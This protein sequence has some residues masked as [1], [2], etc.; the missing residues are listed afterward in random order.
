VTGAA[1]SKPLSEPSPDPDSD[2]PPPSLTDA[3]GAEVGALV[4]SAPCHIFGSAVGAL[5]GSAF[6]ALIGS[7][8]GALIGSELSTLV[9]SAL[10]VAVS[11]PLPES[12]PA[13]VGSCVGSAI[14]ST[15]VPLHMQLGWY[16]VYGEASTG[17]QNATTPV[18]TPSASYAQ[19]RNSAAVGASAS[20]HVHSTRHSCCVEHHSQSGS[21]LQPARSL[22][23]RG[24]LSKT[25]SSGHTEHWVGSPRPEPEPVPADEPG[26]MHRSPVQPLLPLT[27]HSHSENEQTLL[28]HLTSSS[29]YPINCMP[30]AVTQLHP[31]ST[32][33]EV[34]GGVVSNPL[35][36]LAVGCA[37]GQA[38]GVSDGAAVGNSVG[39][40]V[41][42]LL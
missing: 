6:G 7:A 15:L 41:G 36:K 13:E 8:V 12:S 38:A 14:G 33:A 32:G 35:E 25:D 31:S 28:E 39:S 1:V 10:A 29:Q 2:P 37:V 16:S 22:P 40:V 34:V 5:V 19:S 27:V 11:N 3:D 26:D 9:G 21:A 18:G 30:S 17:G 20:L 24:H 42:G 23:K 4:G